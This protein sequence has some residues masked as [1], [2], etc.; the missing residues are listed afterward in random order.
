MIENYKEDIKEKK[1]GSKNEVIEYRRDGDKKLKRG[2][3]ENLKES[4]VNKVE[5][6]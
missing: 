1:E 4:E 3:K 5:D 6:E 2:V